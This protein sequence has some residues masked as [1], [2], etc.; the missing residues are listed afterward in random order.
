MKKRNVN[1][2]L[3]TPV[4][5]TIAASVGFCA[6]ALACLILTSLWPLVIGFA[7]TALVVAQIKE[8]VVMGGDFEGL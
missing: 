5:Q 1:D 8:P 4:Y 7:M 6:S 2:N 3:N